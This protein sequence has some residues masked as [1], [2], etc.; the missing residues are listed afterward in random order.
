[1]LYIH[2]LRDLSQKTAE[3]ESVPIVRSIKGNMH[4]TL[5]KEKMLSHFSGFCITYEDMEIISDSINLINPAINEIKA[6][7]D[8]N[9]P[10]YEAINLQRAV[11][12]L[13][14]VYAPLVNNLNYANEI[15]SCQEELIK[16]ITEILDLLP[17]IKNMEE[18]MKINQKFNVIFQKILR[19]GE[20]KFNYL[21]IINEGKFNRI[22]DLYDS[23]INGFFFHVTVKEHLEKQGFNAIKERIPDSELESSEQITGKVFDIKRGIQRAYECNHRMINL[24][25]VLYSYIK[26]LAK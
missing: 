7:M 1:M 5:S 16:E 10:L 23:L 3:I 18:K 2:E 9:D 26:V 14:E 17:G 20:F 21:D 22:K 13:D 12:M 19:N 25:V 6:V 15:I 11:N 8:K 4:P 24:A